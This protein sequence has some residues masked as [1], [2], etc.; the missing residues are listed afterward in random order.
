LRN[1]VAVA[2]GAVALSYAGGF[3]PAVA[4]EVRPR[5]KIEER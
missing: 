3:D 5:V 2:A 4:D 1:A